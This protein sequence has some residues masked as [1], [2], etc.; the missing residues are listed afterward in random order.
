MLHV[1][2][3]SLTHRTQYTTL[4]CILCKPNSTGSDYR[5]QSVT[6]I[7]HKNYGSNLREAGDGLIDRD[8]MIRLMK[9]RLIGRYDYGNGI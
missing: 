9:I 4:R 6:L 5:R 1:L 2:T 8:A 3:H 7:Y